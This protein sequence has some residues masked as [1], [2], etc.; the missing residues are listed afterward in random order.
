MAVRIRL[1]RMGKNKR[2]FY[3][4]VVADARSAAD[5]EYIESIGYYNPLTDPPEI[6][7]KEE[8]L[9]EWIDKGAKITEPVEKLFKMRQKLSKKGQNF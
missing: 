3:R 8:K 9:K 5:G 6:E 2:P 1:R 4:I 7:I